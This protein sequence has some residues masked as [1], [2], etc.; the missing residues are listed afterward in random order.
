M[1]PILKKIFVIC[2]MLGGWYTSHADARIEGIFELDHNKNISVLIKEI[3]PLSATLAPLEEKATLL[4]SK[5]FSMELKIK[6]PGLFSLYIIVGDEANKSP[7][8][9]TI[10]L[11]PQSNLKLYFF[12]EES[13]S[14]HC[15]FAV[16]KDPSTRSL[17]MMQERINQLMRNSFYN[18]PSNAMQAK[19]YLDSFYKAS[20]SLLAQKKLASPVKKYIDAMAAQSFQSGLY[21]YA[22]LFISEKQY[23]SE[24]LMLAA[25][26]LPKYKNPFILS[27]SASIQNLIGY[28][29]LKIGMAPYA[30]NKSLEQ[31][32]KQIQILK[33]QGF[34]KRINNQTIQSLL[35]NYVMRY[36]ATENFEKDKE[37]FFKLA[38]KI[39]DTNMATVVKDAFSNLKYTIKGA[40]IPPVALVDKEGNNVTLDQFRGR[41]IFI[42]LW[43][44]WCVPC[45]KMTP[46]VKQLEKNYEGKNI[47]FIAISIDASKESWLKKML[48]LK[49]DGH[50]FLDQSAALTQKLNISG[51]PHYLIYS[52]E[53]K[54]L[55]YKADMPDSPKLKQTIDGLLNL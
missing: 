4:D 15:R 32:E 12:Q 50:Q 9:A 21:Q 28:L 10:Y 45:I 44:S 55:I 41:Y 49:L 31:I 46:Y 23:T 7:Y 17:V 24:Y 18:P 22:K 37:A 47:V 54:L 6:K 3:L 51:I 25:K 52:P 27:F 48:E 5:R 30:S 34:D 39:E 16:I 43:A 35:N 14:I 20:D 2:L 26:I 33:E 40:D 1:Q 53:G 42:D 13:A 11:T 36:K 19:A 8:S 29:N 38:D